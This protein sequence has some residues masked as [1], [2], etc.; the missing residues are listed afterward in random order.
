[1][2]RLSVLSGIA[3][4]ATYLLAQP[5]AAQTISVEG[6]S[7]VEIT[8]EFTTLS[9][10]VTQ[11]SKASPAAAQQRVDAAINGLLAM[12]EALPAD[13]ES[14]EA[15]QLRVQPRYRWN[16]TAETQ[17]LVGYEATR[18]FS[19]RLLDLDSVGEALQALSQAGT[20]RLDGPIYG[21]SKVDTARAE[22][23][24]QAY[25][26]ALADARVLASASGLSLGAPETISTGNTGGPIFPLMGRVATEAMSA[27][28]SPRYE[29]GLLQVTASVSV[30]FSTRP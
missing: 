4:M 7:T 20:T 24:G 19:F 1:M 23:L 25:A 3:L 12:I 27:D 5:L 11:I 29:P 10:A 8:P 9:G 22:A 15:G 28:P 30:I 26:R 16:S 13:P 2:S 14:I 18:E 6:R 17:E 21:S